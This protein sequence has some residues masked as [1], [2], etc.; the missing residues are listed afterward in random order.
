MQV[1][2]DQV[3]VIIKWEILCKKTLIACN[4]AHQ[5]FFYGILRGSSEC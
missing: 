1:T 5:S 2:H 4:F 3:G